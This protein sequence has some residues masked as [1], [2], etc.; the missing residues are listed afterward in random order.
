SQPDAEPDALVQEALSQF[1]SRNPTKGD[2]VAISVSGQAGL[3]RFIK[4]PPVESK[5][6]PD[7]VKFEARQQIPFPL[8]GVIW[9]YQQLP[10][11]TVEEGF[12]LETEVGLFAMKREQV[13]R[14]L[15]PFDK[16]GIELDVVQLT[17]L[18][19][20]NFA[21]FDMLPKV[22]YDPNSPPPSVAIV[23]MGTET[24]DLVI[25]NGYRVW[26]RSI[27]IGGNHFTKQLTK[28]LKMTFAK[29]EHLKRN[30]RQAENPKAIITAMSPVFKDLVS[31]LQRSIGFFRNN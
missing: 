19:L 29:A 27:P 23:S 28:E 15:A 14:E 22:D 18:C 10:G 6:I 11:G 5:K 26:Q 17:P 20:Y 24:T 7:L 3:A 31:E 12:S 21:A 2:K 25:T 1:L 4:L 13:D 16:A 9:D 30:V 8:E